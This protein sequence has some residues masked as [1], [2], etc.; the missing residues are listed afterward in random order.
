MGTHALFDEAHF[1]V[2]SSNA[3]LAAQALQRLGY[4]NFDN[5]F[6]DGSFIPDATIKINFSAKPPTQSTSQSIGLDIYHS[7]KDI[8]IHPQ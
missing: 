1:T 7:G 3:P 5:E 4:A 6:K 2:Q 8:T